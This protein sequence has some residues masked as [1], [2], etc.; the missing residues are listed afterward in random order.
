MTVRELSQ[1]YWLNREIPRDEERIA[2]LRAKA[3][4][5]PSPDMSGMPHGSGGNTSRTE[6]YAVELAS[7]EKLL[8]NRKAERDR[9]QSFINDIP[10]SLTR[11]IFSYRF[12][13]NL[14]WKEVAK[15]IGCGNT[16]ESVKKRCYRYLDEEYNSRFV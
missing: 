7:R 5:A 1:L 3:Q 8:M 4:S 6:K 14:S 12:E 16:D 13:N 10:D 9:L 15:K 2:Q 11:L